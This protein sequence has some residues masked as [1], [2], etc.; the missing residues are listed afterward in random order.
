MQLISISKKK[1]INTEN[2][3]ISQRY[4]IGPRMRRAPS[5]LSLLSD[6]SCRCNDCVYRDI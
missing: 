5:L 3:T 1:S 4:D 6:V 2:K